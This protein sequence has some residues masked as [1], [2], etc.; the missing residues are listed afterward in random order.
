M[1]KR[2]AVYEL[3]KVPV[4]MKN[5]ASSMR[6]KIGKDSVSDEE[7][8]LVSLVETELL[9]ESLS[10][11]DAEIEVDDDADSEAD[12]DKLSLVVSD[13]DA[14]DVND[15]DTDSVALGEGLADADSLSEAESDGV[16]DFDA[17]SEKESDSDAETD[18]ESDALSDAETDAVRLK[19]P[20]GVDETVAPERDSVR[21]C[22]VEAVGN[23][24]VAEP[25]VV[26]VLENVADGVGAGVIV[27]EMLRDTVGPVRA[28]VL[29][30]RD[31]LVPRRA[32]DPW[33]RRAQLRFAVN[34]RKPFYINW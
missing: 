20:L 26:T 25:V 32:G 16:D 2:F 33:H 27:A 15:A 24:G 29:R 1:R 34:I 3:L 13:S 31:G 4:K 14:V 9:A 18:D 19:V 11:S 10:D 28:A 17:D 8:E 22:D 23:D 21:E 6:D 30:G 7:A 5:P 12:D